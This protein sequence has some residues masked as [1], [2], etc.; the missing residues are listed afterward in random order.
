MAEQVI[1]NS[2]RIVPAL[3]CAALVAAPLY[4]LATEFRVLLAVDGHRESVVTREKTV[5]GLL[6]SREVAVG[7]HDVV[8]PGKG[9][10]LRDGMEVA[11][12]RALPVTLD[13]NGTVTTVW[14][15]STRVSDVLD[16]LDLDAELVRPARTAA[17]RRGD[18]LVVRDLSRVTVARDGV[19]ASVVTAAR[20]V[21]E[22]LEHMG[23]AVGPQDEVAPGLDT[24]PVAGS[25]I[26]VVRVRF[27]DVVERKAVPF[28]TVERDD[29]SLRLGT[30]KETQ[31][32]IRG[33]S[34]TGYRVELRDGVVVS[35]RAI[36]VEVVQPPRPRI[37]AVGTRRPQS[38]TGG[39]SWYDARSMTCAHRTITFGT[40]VTVRNVSNGKSVTCTVADRGPYVAGR[41][42][43]LDRDAFAVIS[44]TS[45]GVVQVS[46]EW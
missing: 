44:P 11:V 16:E 36:S 7:P 2:R 26:R 43:D 25:T 15:T 12:A 6:E 19:E 33:I 14:S 17:L 4:L 37:V 40:R 41:I 32:G 24:V 34:S 46:I 8:H 13:L 22:L 28:A 42:I 20:S 30:R 35:K 27:E 38:A 29:P 10:N 45:K 3:L 31:K 1:R 18:T 21:R 23:I 5:E 9:H 39:A